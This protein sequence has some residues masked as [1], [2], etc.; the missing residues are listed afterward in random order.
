MMSEFPSDGKKKIMQQKKKKKKIYHIVFESSTVN[1]A[2][3][4]EL[5]FYLFWKV[6][7]A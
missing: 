7:E 6:Y 2:R 4:W 3:L 5:A 1:H